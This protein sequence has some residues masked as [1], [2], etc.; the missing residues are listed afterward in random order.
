M[1]AFVEKHIQENFPD[2]PKSRIHC[3]FH[4]GRRPFLFFMLPD[5]VSIHH[6]HLHLIIL[7]G[8]LVWLL[9]YPAWN[10]FM[11]LSLDKVIKKLQAQKRDD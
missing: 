9:K 8:W 2:V 1:K 3:G 11:W 7:P 10:P 6:L 5:I 4:R